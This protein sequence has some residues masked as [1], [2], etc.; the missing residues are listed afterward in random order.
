MAGK[1]EKQTTSENRGR[2]GLPGRIVPAQNGY[3]AALLIMAVVAI[4]FLVMVIILNMLPADLTL[5]LVLLMLGM[6]LAADLLFAGRRRWQRIC[7]I[8]VAV[9]FTVIFIGASSY[10][11][12]TH[13][14][15]ENISD[16]GISAT[17]P[18]A[19]SVEVTEEPFN[20]Y[21]TGIDQWESEIGYD[22][23]R[24]DVNMICTV[25]PRTKK[26]LLTSIPRDTYVK[27][28]TAQQMDKLTHTGVYGV[29]ETLDT[30]HDWMG[31]DLNY[32]VKMNFTGA[33]DI[34]NA[35]DGVNMYSPIAFKSSLEDY[36][37]VKGWNAMGGEKCLYYAREREAFGG[38]DS[39]RVENQQRVLKAVIK[40]MTSSTTLL[41]K[42]GDIVEAAGRNLATN[43]PSE[44]M[45]KLVKMQISDLSD[46]DIET[47]KIEG[48]YD[49]D[50]VASLS[51]ENKY[52]VYRPD[53]ESVRS[54]KENIDKVMNEG[55]GDTAGIRKSKSFFVNAAKRV[56][57]EKE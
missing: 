18:K 12:K 5:T 36:E 52:T 13:A 17:G 10:M 3:R 33:K 30:V 34:I 49:E 45:K 20:I 7:G 32:Y 22:L 4:V 55:A 6:L 24:S 2:R 29:D 46:W 40:K 26:I 15:L 43:M 21:I 39:I 54:C 51:Q 9:L 11:G 16:S 41:T 48:E 31:V 1:E 53:R 37:Y 14:M 47:Q 35:M 42:Y 38:K 28:H 57:E 27:L 44:D 23:E 8:V 56:L 25:N 50:Y 19:R